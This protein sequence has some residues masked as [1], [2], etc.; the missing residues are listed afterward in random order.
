MYKEEATLEHQMISEE[1]YG[2][3]KKIHNTA[4][5]YSADVESIGLFLSNLE[6]NYS[7]LFVFSKKLCAEGRNLQLLNSYLLKEVTDR[8]LFELGKNSEIE[9]LKAQLESEAK[10][11]NFFSSRSLNSD[12]RCLSLEN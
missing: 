11:K 7:R 5:L 4:Q 6:H 3:Y 9:D 8:H 12:Q 1:V 10:I 2:M